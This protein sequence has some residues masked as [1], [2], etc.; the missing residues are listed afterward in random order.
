MKEV[1]KVMLFVHD[2]FIKKSCLHVKILLCYRAIVLTSVN[3]PTH[4]YL[5]IIVDLRLK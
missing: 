3:L 5:T 2:G 1:E 4:F